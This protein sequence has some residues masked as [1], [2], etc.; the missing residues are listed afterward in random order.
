MAEPSPE[1]LTQLTTALRALGAA[2]LLLIACTCPLERELAA[3]VDQLMASHA[4]S[5]LV[6]VR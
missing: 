1:S 5:L 2:R 3:Q 6:Q 4:S